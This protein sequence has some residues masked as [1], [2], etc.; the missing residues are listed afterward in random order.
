MTETEIDETKEAAAVKEMFKISVREL[1]AFSCFAPDIMPVTDT[2]ALLTG[3]QAHRSRQEDYAGET[4]KTIKYIYELHGAR[5]QV[6]GRMDAPCRCG[7]YLAD[8]GTVNLAFV[9][10]Y[11]QKGAIGTLC[12]INPTLRHKYLPTSRRATQSIVI[13]N[14]STTRWCYR[15]AKHSTGPTPSC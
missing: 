12:H 7:G 1:V 6:Y 15:S 2:N 5:V 10:S 13:L 11:V 8:Y 9:S 3:A 14:I 4:E